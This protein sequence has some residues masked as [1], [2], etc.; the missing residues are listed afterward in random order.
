MRHNYHIYSFKIY[1][2]L[3]SYTVGDLNSSVICCSV[4]N[5]PKIQSVAVNTVLDNFEGTTPSSWKPYLDI[6]SM[7]FHSLPDN[8]VKRAKH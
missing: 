7:L 3:R 8:V 2:I 4:T 1:I 6:S 5:L